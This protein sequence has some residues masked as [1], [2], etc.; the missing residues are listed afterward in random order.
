MMLKE[1]SMR[2]SHL[3]DRTKESAQSSRTLLNY[4]LLTLPLPFILWFITFINP[5]IGFWPMLTLSTSI[6]F[7]VSLFRIRSIRFKPTSRGVIIGTVTGVFLFVFFYFGAQIA[8]S[9]PGFKTQVSAVY[10]YRGNFPLQMIAV[11]LLFPIGSGEALYWQ[12]FIL[13]YLDKWL[14]PWKASV[15]MSFLYMLIHLPTFNTSLMIV[16]L[17]VGLTWSFLFNKIDNNLFPVML[18]HIIFDELAFVLFMIG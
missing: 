5:L 9:I 1:I 12:G 2:F 8:N 7:T 15:L 13:R 17:I 3:F 18:S 11:L 6:L 10:N 14:K 4:E 16:S